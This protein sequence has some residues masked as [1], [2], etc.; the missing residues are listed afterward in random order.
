MQLDEK[1]LEIANDGMSVNLKSN[2]LAMLFHKR[3]GLGV[4]S[5]KLRN[6]SARKRRASEEELAQFT[7]A[8]KIIH[9]LTSNKN[10]S[11]AYL[12]ASIE[13]GQDLVTTYTKKSNAKASKQ[14]EESYCYFSIE[15]N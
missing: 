1:E 8:E 12:V 7:P 11:V 2:G 4:N 13:V 5:K 9:V 14:A 3:R 15:C 6:Y 10:V